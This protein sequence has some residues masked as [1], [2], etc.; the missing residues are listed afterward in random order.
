MSQPDDLPRDAVGRKTAVN[1]V[2]FQHRTRELIR[3]ASKVAEVTFGKSAVKELDGSV[4]VSKDAKVIAKLLPQEPG[5][6]EYVLLGVSSDYCPQ[7]WKDMPTPFD[8][9]FLVRESPF[10]FLLLPDSSPEAAAQ[11]AGHV[12]GELKA[13]LPSA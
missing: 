8:G 4:S 12:F 3:A 5:Q 10:H 6:R 13:R 1:L 2:E 9:P 11:V 7:D